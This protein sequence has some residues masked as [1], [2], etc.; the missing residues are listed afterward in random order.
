MSIIFQSGGILTTV[1]DLGR[2]GFRHLG[3]N[4]NGAMDTAAARLVNILLDNA[5]SEGV[6]EIHFPAPKILFAENT[7]IALGG[8]DFGARIDEKQVES[9]RPIFVE[10]GGVLDFPQKIFGNRAYLAIR[11]G[12][13]I[14]DWLGSASTNLKAQA[15]GFQGRNLRKG[16]EIHF[17]KSLNAAPRNLR[18]KI[19]K[20][21]IPQYSSLPTV[22]VVA[23]AEFENLDVE[24][25]KLFQTQNFSVRHESDRMGFRLEGENLKLKKPLE[26]ISSAAGFGTIQLL[27]GGQ[28]II[29]M[30]DH[31]TTG[32]Y[33]RLANIV[34]RDL[35]LVGQLGAND[36]LNFKIISIQEAENLILEFEKDLNLL[37]TACRFLC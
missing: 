3:I 2:V 21:L 22:R 29:L 28:L 1:Q 26:M 7:V 36:R 24:S 14:K 4:P 16:D 19:S 11:G 9:W 5:E 17:K 34:S 18:V 20:T 31:Q 35:P 10:K 33:P 12:L 30:A 23:A 13:A 37:K 32:G 27:P 15:G 25:R 8:A 6:L